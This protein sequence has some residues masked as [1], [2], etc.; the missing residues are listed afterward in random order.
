MDLEGWEILPDYGF[1]EIHDVDGGGGKKIFSRECYTDSININQS[2]QSQHE[3]LPVDD[4]HGVESPVVF[5]QA[6]Q[7]VSQ[8]FFKKMKEAEFS[9]T[10]KMESPR[11]NSKSF[12][13]KVEVGEAYR[14]KAMEGDQMD[15]G[16]Q[17]NGGVNI[18]RWSFNGI[19]AICSFGVAAAAAAT[20]CIIFIGNT[21]KHRHQNHKLCFQICTDNKR[22]KKAVHPAPKLDEAN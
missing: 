17:Q 14:R 6:E 10:A 13:P 18:W 3:L 11:S 9:G 2:T 20:L 19:G 21:Q 16:V 7:E 5:D 15:G 8:V 4:D 1:L 22:I 12:V